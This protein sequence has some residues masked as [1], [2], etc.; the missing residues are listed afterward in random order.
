MSDTDDITTTPD[1]AALTQAGL[2]LIQQALSIYD[3]ELRFV[4]GNRTFQTMFNLPKRLV[5]RGADFEDTIRYL[6]ETGEYGPVDDPE[7]F[8]RDRVEAARA[9]EPHYMERSR[10]NGR[11]I[12]VEGSPLPQG[13]WVTVYTDIT[14]IKRQEALLRARS[15]ELSDQVIAH[16][17]D[18]SHANRELA[19]TNAALEEAKRQLT[20]MEARARV[21][22]EM[23]PAHIARIDRNLTY[24]YSNRQLGS[25]LPG[26]PRNI[27]GLNTR[28]VL[29]DA[30]F[31]TIEG[32]LK[33]AL[34]G[35]AS[36][37]EFADEASGRRV[38]VAFTPDVGE[39]GAVTGVYFLSMDVTEEAQARAAL[40]QTRKRELAAQ[41]TSGMAHDFSNLL[42]IILGMQAKLMQMDLPPEARNLI[43][44]TTGAARRGGALLDRIA[45]LSGA[46]IVRAEPVEVAR[47]LAE[48]ETLAGPS[49]PDGVTLSIICDAPATPVLLDTGAVQDALLNLILNAR[50]ALDGSGEIRV[51]ARP[52]AETW[53]EFEVRD[54][55]PGFSPDALEHGL[56]AFYTTKGGEGSGL[57]LAMVYDQAKAAGGQVRLANTDRGAQV[58]MRLPL[59]PATGPAPRLVLLV[60]DQSEIRADVRDMLIALGHQVIEAESGEEALDLAGIDGIGLVL[61]DIN[62]GGEWTGDRLIAALRDR[63]LAAPMVLMSS[64]PPGDPRRGVAPTLSKPFTQAQLA[65]FLASE[66]AP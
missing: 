18:L 23:M 1:I 27:V 12:S 20:E 25:V 30:V 41:L 13:G 64:L 42:T 61:S 24:T 21:T 54:T 66:V 45:T 34:D 36:V 29:G 48:T 40:M 8:V 59:K 10:S 35:A 17:E 28:D 9:F 14:A 52:V 5:T 65:A 39:D 6:V 56:D 53:L 31:A 62:L 19:A 47:L 58:T 43:D 60:E 38:R 4:V 22:A 63:G 49:L 16:S 44:A 11:M 15:A 50:D 32:N 2:N 3:S 55:G 7:V 33:L 26:R 46:R 37:L 57:G 51:T